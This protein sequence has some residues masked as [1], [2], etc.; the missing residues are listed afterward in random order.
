MT[1]SSGPGNG[2]QQNLKFQDYETYNPT[3][4]SM[5]MMMKMMMQMQELM[6]QQQ[7][8]FI[9]MTNFMTT[10]I[11][12]QMRKSNRHYFKNNIKCYNCLQWGHYAKFCNE[13]QVENTSIIENSSM[14]L[15]SSPEI[16]PNTEKYEYSISNGGRHL[17]VS[18]LNT[19]IKTETIKVFIPEYQSTKFECIQLEGVVS[20]GTAIDGRI[21]LNA[22][23][24]MGLLEKMKPIQKTYTAATFD[25]NVDSVGEITLKI[26]YDEEP[27]D[28]KLIVFEESTE[29]IIF[30]NA[31]MQRTHWKPSWILSKNRTECYKLPNSDTI[32][33]KS[34]RNA[35]KDRLILNYVKIDDPNN[36]D[37]TE[38]ADK[39]NRIPEY[40]ELQRPDGQLKGKLAITKILSIE[41]E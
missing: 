24:N 22:V 6:Q 33:N 17:S 14:S 16:I 19:A 32:M 10:L 30:G 18:R 1:I 26:I 39:I 4:Q 13:P 7:Q 8:Q 27:Y 20:T 29:D 41:F 28:V 25:S 15:N 35:F 2:Q 21:S 3:D 5:N 36:R 11:E 31:L 40:K 23:N 9:Q 38:S 34:Q 37:S 12:N